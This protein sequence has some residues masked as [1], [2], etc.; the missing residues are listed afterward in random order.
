MSACSDACDH[1]GRC[2]A[3]NERDSPEFECSWCGNIESDATHWP[4]CSESCANDAE[5][6][7]R[8]DENPRERDEDDGRTYAD[9]RDERDD[10]MERD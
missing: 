2:T 7:S 5:G 3:E 1:C 8:E 6:E 10:R 4:Y 9:P